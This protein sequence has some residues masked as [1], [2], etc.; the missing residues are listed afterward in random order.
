MAPSVFIS[1]TARADFSVGFDRTSAITERENNHARWARLGGT[2]ALPRGFTIGASVEQRWTRWDG[3]WFPFTPA[4]TQRRDK[5][6]TFR[7]SV[8]NRGF[9]FLGFS[10]KLSWVKEMSNT[11]AQL[12]DYSRVR[13]EVEM[14]RQF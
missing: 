13:Y 11:N 7:L 6:R 8:L 4:N 3:T 14:V 10:P 12:R 2:K 9:T 1:P 5:G